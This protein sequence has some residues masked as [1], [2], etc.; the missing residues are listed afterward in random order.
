[1]MSIYK[2]IS[3]TK[4]YDNPQCDYGWLYISIGDDDVTSCKIDYQT[5]VKLTYQL[6]KQLGKRVAMSNNIFNP[7]ITTVEIN[8]FLD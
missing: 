7:M 6:A 8:G 5:A 2:S 1:M 3:F 4:F